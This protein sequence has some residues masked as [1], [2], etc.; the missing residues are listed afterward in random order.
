MLANDAETVRSAVA[1]VD[2]GLTQQTIVAVDDRGGVRTGAQA[3]FTIAGETGGLIGFIGRALSPRPVS[4]L[5]EPVYRLF[6]RHRGRF[7]RWF[8]NPE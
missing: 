7:A 5:F 3:I 8:K 2:P 1:T 4:L 6:A